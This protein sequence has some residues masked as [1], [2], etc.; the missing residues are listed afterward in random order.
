[1][2]ASAVTDSV[3]LSPTVLRMMYHMFGFPIRLQA[4]SATKYATGANRQ[5]TDETPTFGRV[6][7]VQRFYFDS[8]TRIT[9]AVVLVL[10][11]AYHRRRELRRQGVVYAALLV[12][13]VMP[14][15]LRRR[16]C[17]TDD[18]RC[19]YVLR[20]AAAR[21]HYTAVEQAQ[22]V[23]GPRLHRP[24]VGNKLERKLSDAGWR[25]GGLIGNSVQ[26]TYATRRWR[27]GTPELRTQFSLTNVREPT[28]A[29]WRCSDGRRPTLATN[30]CQIG[31]ESCLWSILLTVQQQ[32]LCLPTLV[33]VMAMLIGFES[34]RVCS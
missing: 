2:T 4:W 31:D 17:S 16:S 20:I 10:A 25:A 19:T 30:D 15:S 14:S 32:S 34:V 26:R 13:I 22:Y 5:Q 29:Q 11:S 21:V 12:G 28:Y 33:Q 23:C 6:L 18:P 8:S 7:K 24:P 3:L 1:M 27:I 9:Q